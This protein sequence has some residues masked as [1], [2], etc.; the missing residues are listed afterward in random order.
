MV[1]FYSSKVYLYTSNDPIIEASR[2]LQFG[3]YNIGYPGFNIT[4][5]TADQ[6]QNLF[7]Q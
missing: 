2:G 4:N 7:E 1:F 3:P 5:T 6:A